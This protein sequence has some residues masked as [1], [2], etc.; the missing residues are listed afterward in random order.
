MVFFIFLVGLNHPPPH[1]NDTLICPAKQAEGPLHGGTRF[2][3]PQGATN[4]LVY[5]IL[6]IAKEQIK[7]ADGHR[8]GGG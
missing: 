7:H 1:P 6:S 5:C 2:K 4:I 8:G 3:Q